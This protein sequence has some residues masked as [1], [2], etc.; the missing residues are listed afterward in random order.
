MKRKVMRLLACVLAA[1]MV[2]SFPMTAVAE[3]PEEDS[4]KDAVIE[5]MTESH[6]ENPTEKKEILDDVKETIEE[7][8]EK[9]EEVPKA[10]QEQ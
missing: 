8:F 4:G 5:E 10:E 6:K 1:S 2:L 3:I 9:G 7:I